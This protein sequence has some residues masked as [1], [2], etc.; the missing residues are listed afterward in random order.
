[1][2]KVLKFEVTDLGKV[3]REYMSPDESKIRDSLKE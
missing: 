2:R 1:M 3:P